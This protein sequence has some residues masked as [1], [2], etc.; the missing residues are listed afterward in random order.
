VLHVTGHGRQCCKVKGAGDERDTS[1]DDAAV[2]YCIYSNLISALSCIYQVR[3]PFVLGI[4]E[5]HAEST[6]ENG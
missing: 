1:L 4:P 3:C 5:P 2:F 6:H